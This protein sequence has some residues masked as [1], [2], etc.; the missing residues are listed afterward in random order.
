LIL[1]E[2]PDRAKLEG[3]V[4]ELGLEGRMELPG[5]VADPERVLG[6]SAVFVLS[7]W[8]EGFPNALLEAMA[9]GCAV[10][11][12]D[13]PSGPGEIVRPGVDGFLVPVG[14]VEAL[15]RALDELMGDEGLR[16]RL[17]EQA[18]KVRER[19]GLEQVM[20]LWEDLLEKVAGQ[21]SFRRV[22]EFPGRI[23]GGYR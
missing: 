2:G 7:S 1:G 5:W 12:T 8:Y 15:A 16:R 20:G 22:A 17:G 14:E 19:F 4:R 6:E 10:V 21:G 11:A 9:A 18:R 23:S 13:C 3:M